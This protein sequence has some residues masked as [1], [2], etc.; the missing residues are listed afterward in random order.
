LAILLE[1]KYSKEEIIELYLNQ[2]PYGSNAY[3]VA[4]AA[5]TFFGKERTNANRK[6]RFGQW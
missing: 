6:K 2:I 1:Q 5:Q 4:A 3:G